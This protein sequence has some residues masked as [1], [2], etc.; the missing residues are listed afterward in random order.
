M[1][2]KGPVSSLMLKATSSS[3]SEPNPALNTSGHFLCLCT[4]KA[5]N[6]GYDAK[7]KQLNADIRNTAIQSRP[8]SGT[9]IF[10]DIFENYIINSFLNEELI[11]GEI[12]DMFK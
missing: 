1:C 7:I 8:H 9:N 11:Q 5:L 12:G 3:S 10:Y 4:P 2:P 6:P